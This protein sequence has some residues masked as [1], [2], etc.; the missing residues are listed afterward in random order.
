MPRPP[1][2]PGHL[3]LA[4]VVTWPPGSPPRSPPSPSPSL[5][6]LSLSL[7]L[8]FEA[9]REHAVA[10]VVRK[11]GHRAPSVASSCLAELPWRASLFRAINRARQP[12]ETPPSSP[13][14][15]W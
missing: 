12:L 1:P 13:R 9:T 15:R 8:D 5:C 4:P 11:H 6:F 7:L 3:L 14:H 2:S 10:A